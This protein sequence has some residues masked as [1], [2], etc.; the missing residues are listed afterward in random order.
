ME[1]FLKDLNQSQRE[2]V[3]Y[4]DGPSL[5]IAGAG[6]GKTRVLTYKI[7][8]LLQ[9]GYAPYNI[10][11][12]TFTNKAAREMKERI[13][14]MV[15]ADTASRLWMGTFHSIF[16][17][18]LRTYA[19]RIGFDSK[20]T[21]Y[22]S[23]DSRNLI[24]TIIKEMSLDDKLYKPATVQAIISNAKNALITPGAYA[25]RKEL[26]EADIRS[27]KPLIKDI[28][29]TYWNRCARAGAMDFDDLLLYTNILFRD[30]PDVREHYGNIF[31]YVLVDEYQ[32]TNFAQHL[33]V[34]QLAKDHNHIC[35]VGD[36]AQSIYSFRGANISNILNLK[37]DYPGCR[38]F[39][40]EQN[41]RS[42][43]MIVAAANSL[44]EKNKEQIP[45][46]VF[47]D[48]DEGSKIAVLNAYSDFEEGYMIANRISEM[49]A[50][51]GFSYSD[52]AILY[53]TNAQSRIF[54]EALRKKNIPYKIYGGVSFYQ[55]KEIKDIVAYFR[56]TVNPH[57]EEALKRIINYPARGIGDT[58]V[59]KIGECATTHNVS[60]WQVVSDPL[61][62]ALPVNNGT[63]NKLKLFRDLI[64]SFRDA[65]GEKNAYDLSEQIIKQS[66]IFADVFSDRTP[67]NLSRQE[68][69]Q[70]LMNGV[71]EFCSL[72][73]EEGNESVSL[74]DFLSEVSLATDQ[75][76]DKE[77][78][79]DKVTMMT[80]HAS[81]GLEFTNVFVVGLEEDLFPAA[82]SKNSERE[83]EEERRLLYV[84]ITRAEK[85][86]ILSY[87]GT[88]YR[89]GQPAA[90]PPSR[91]LKDLD[92]RYISLSAGLDND[93]G[94][95][96][97]KPEDMRFPSGG[98]FGRVRSRQA[99][100]ERSDSVNSWNNRIG[101]NKPEHHRPLTRM[102]Q[103]MSKEPSITSAS[104]H[105]DLQVGNIIRHDRFGQGRIIEISGEGDNAKIGVEFENVGKKQLL[106]KFAKFT[107]I[108]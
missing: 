108:E 71:Q 10:L 59:R 38:T 39:K 25:A 17:R 11:A 104:K 29:K 47:S 53:R 3:L 33:I 48:N 1:E 41:Y 101:T 35:V 62:Y 57:D 44:I 14:R 21:I 31:R 43:Q 37:T 8:Y 92:T 13:S 107:V 87:A 65:A 20:F 72:R 36:D 58:T 69:L 30:H 7:A 55:R 45:K 78:N 51:S 42:T 34:H 23:A 100:P 27:N 98:V 32:D 82:M 91:F 64:E 6:S 9:S 22:D 93:K 66:G 2:A 77:E 84:A 80:V 86:C 52:F 19:D 18:I 105:G 73:E 50:V 12:L 79:S 16:L 89:N 96:F 56:L 67:E 76:N 46:H 49:R 28:Y 97:E 106:L 74:I 54:E 40:L 26:I 61:A 75:D 95:G 24:K 99:E 63:L 102:E 4:N 85:N 70:E 90:M 81:K 68:N 60:L 15:G 88:R 5:V 103:A 83:I 94:G